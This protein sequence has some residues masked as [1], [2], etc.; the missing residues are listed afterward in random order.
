MKP[1]LL[2]CALLVV[3]GCGKVMA[4]NAPLDVAPIEHREFMGFK[5]CHAVGDGN[6]TQCD[7]PLYDNPTHECADKSRFLLMSEDGRWH[8]LALAPENR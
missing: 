8:C 1:T 6:M 2:A 3:C 7:T 5:D 4:Q